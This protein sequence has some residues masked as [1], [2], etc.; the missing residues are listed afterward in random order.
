VKKEN[1][2]S[3]LCIFYPTALFF[4]RRKPGGIMQNKQI[5]GFQRKRKS[6]TGGF[7]QHA[8]AKGRET[9]VKTARKPPVRGV[10]NGG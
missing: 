8:Q 4:S 6:Y 7:W 10:K 9:G 3:L 2:S 5:Y 1:F